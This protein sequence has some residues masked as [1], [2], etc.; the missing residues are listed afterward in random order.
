MKWFGE[1]VVF[2][3]NLQRKKVLLILKCLMLNG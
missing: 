3:K 2:M 1:G